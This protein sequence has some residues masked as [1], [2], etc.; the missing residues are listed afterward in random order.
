[1][2]RVQTSNQINTPP[3]KPDPP[4]VDLL[5]THV[6]RPYPPDVWSTEETPPSLHDVG[7][8]PPGAHSAL[9]TSAPSPAF[10]VTLF[11]AHHVAANGR[12]CDT[13]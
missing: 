13:R 9:V 10:F 6:V 5:A 1:M 7:V 3:L 11:R 12:N 2:L 8:S 4:A